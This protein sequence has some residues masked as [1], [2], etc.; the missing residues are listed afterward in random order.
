MLAYSP[1]LRRILQTAEKQIRA[2]RGI[3]HKEF[4]QEFAPEP[5]E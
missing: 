2:G 1:K 4:W 3:K 5:D